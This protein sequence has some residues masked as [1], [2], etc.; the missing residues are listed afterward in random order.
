MTIL[1]PVQTTLPPA[2]D[3]VRHRRQ[4]HLRRLR[5][6]EGAK[7]DLH[8]QSQRRLHLHPIRLRPIPSLDPRYQSVAPSTARSLHR[9]ATKAE[10]YK[11]GNAS[12]VTDFLLFSFQQQQQIQTVIRFLSKV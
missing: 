10:K 7:V 3:S 2:V 5:R 1:M 6:L 11:K 12:S 8:L 4:C 9:T